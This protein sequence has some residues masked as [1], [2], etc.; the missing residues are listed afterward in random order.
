MTKLLRQFYEGLILIGSALKSPLLLVL[1]LYWGWLFAHGAL[2]KLM[3]IE[4]FAT[5]LT[6]LHF[7]FPLFQAYLAA[8]IEFVGG[9]CLMLGLGSRLAAIPLMIV[10]LT[11]YATAHSEG[12]K[13]IFSEPSR[14]VS[15]PPFNFLLTCLIVFAFGPGRLS[16]DYFLEKYYFHPERGS[17]KI[18][19]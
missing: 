13:A 17:K 11:A 12:F 1:R 18:K 8:T 6:N 4:H 2:G 5:L 3:D 19:D 9:I 7:P 14:F 10:M 15:Q 16:I